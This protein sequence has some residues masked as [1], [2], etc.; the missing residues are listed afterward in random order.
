[1]DY[2]HRDISARFRLYLETFPAVLI[3]GP[4]QCGKSTFV[5]NELPQAARF[6]LERPA[7]FQLLSAD[8]ELLF[9]EHPGQSDY[10]IGAG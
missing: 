1:M 6:D 3:L 5:I 9:S 7:D 10:L 4:R 8:P 2:V